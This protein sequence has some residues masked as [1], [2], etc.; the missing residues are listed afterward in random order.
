M[1][2]KLLKQMAKIITLNCVRNTVIED[3]MPEEAIPGRNEGL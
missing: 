2:E 3:T 1:D